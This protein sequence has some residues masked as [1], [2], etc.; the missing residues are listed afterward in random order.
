MIVTDINLLE[1]LPKTLDTR[2][3]STHLFGLLET[4]YNKSSFIKLNFSGIEFMSRSF[5]DQFHKERLKFQSIN[6]SLI[7]LKNAN[8]QIVE[9]LHAVSNTQTKRSSIDLSNLSILTFSNSEQLEEYMF[10]L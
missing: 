10:A 8:Q 5:A 6:N 4:N 2:E 3:S 1:I 7:E 9:I